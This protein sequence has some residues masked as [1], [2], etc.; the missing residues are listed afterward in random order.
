MLS[1]LIA[2]PPGRIMSLKDLRRVT[3]GVSYRKCLFPARVIILREG[4]VSRDV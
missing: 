3:A 4:P 2:C 1:A